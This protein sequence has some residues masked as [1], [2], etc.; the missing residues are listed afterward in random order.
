M[1]PGGVQDDE[2]LL[3]Q[4]THGPGKQL[5]HLSFLAPTSALDNE[6]LLTMLDHIVQQIGKRG[7]FHLLA[8]VEERS[9]AFE[10]LRQAGFALYVHQRIWQSP[11]ESQET[12]LPTAW[13]DSGGKAGR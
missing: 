8:E 4:V 11:A 7:A 1:H 12:N 13:R 9:P 5:A 2:T 6:D 10:N 3:G